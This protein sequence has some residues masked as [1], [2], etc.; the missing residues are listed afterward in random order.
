[1]KTANL[2]QQ[3]LLTASMALVIFSSWSYAG[4]QSSILKM[5]RK[6]LPTGDAQTLA[7]EAKHGPWLILATT[8]S[9]EDAQD[10]AVALANEIRTTMKLPSFVLRKTF[11]NSGVLGSTTKLVNEVDGSTTKYRAWTQYA[12]GGREEV[13][14]VLV[15]EFSSTEDPRIDETLNRIRLADPRTL[16]GPA[17]ATPKSDSNWL[18][19][20]YRSMI[21][22]RTDRELNQQKGPMGAAFVTRNPLLPDDFFQAPK[23]DD[24]VEDL[25]RQ[26][27]HSL[28]ECPGRFT[29]RVASFYGNASTELGEGPSTKSGEATG[30]LDVAA[31]RANKLTLALREQGQEAY[32]FHDRVGSYVTIG[33]FD[34]LGQQDKQGGFHYDQRMVTIMKQFCGYETIQY[35]DPRTGAAATRNSLKQLKKIPFD[36]E[37]KPMAVPRRETSAIYGGSLL[38]GR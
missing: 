18:V 33:S 4:D 37:G 16:G 21:W 27:K 22:S 35:R 1:M 15:G 6:K 20:K 14:A 30:A 32:Q 29:V 11:D 25:N 31:D 8:L 5:F 38:G 19:Q 36:L 28:L 2:S 13:F 24:F 26:V 12:N 9:G 10:R 34:E 23:I 17:E 3:T 7:L